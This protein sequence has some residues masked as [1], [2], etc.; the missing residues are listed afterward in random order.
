MIRSIPAVAALGILVAMP[1]AVYLLSSPTRQER[2]AVRGAAES[3]AVTVTVAAEVLVYLFV[4]GILG[5][6]TAPSS[7]HF[8]RAARRSQCRHS[9]Y[10]GYAYPRL[11][12]LEAAMQ[13]YRR[14][15]G[16]SHH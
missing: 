16:D 1:V 7:A 4:D 14:A 12:Q 10:L 13:H 6:R 9:N 15:F 5:R 3:A 11:R 8:S 2:A